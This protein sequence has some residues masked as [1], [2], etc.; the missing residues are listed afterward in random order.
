MAA[1]QRRGL[2]SATTTIHVC[3][4]CRAPG[5]TLEPREARAG[6]R[7]WRSLL[8]DAEARDYQINPVECLSVCKRPCTVAL[9]APGKWTYVYGDLVAETAS[10]IIL[11]GAALYRDAPDGIVA[12]RSRPDALKR[13]VVA[14]L[15]P[16][17]PEP[18]S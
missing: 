16:L 10:A 17:E 9:S 13:G 12:W 6:F 7:L 4:T 11:A 1:G 18:S 8:G 14:R 15:P 3:T 2:V 5:E